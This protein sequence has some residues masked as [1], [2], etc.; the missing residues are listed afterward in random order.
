MKSIRRSTGT[1]ATCADDD[2]DLSV[3]SL[4]LS[5]I[6]EENLICSTAIHNVVANIEKR[7]KSVRFDQVEVI[8]FPYIL[9]DNPSVSFGPPISM[10]HTH[11]DRF[12]VDL[13]EYDDA[14][15]TIHR[16]SMQ[17]MKMDQMLRT[18][19]LQSSGHS[20]RDIMHATAEAQAAQE[21]RRQSVQSSAANLMFHQARTTARRRIQSAQSSFSSLKQS[22]FAT[23]AHPCDQGKHGERQRQRL[24]EP[25]R[26][27]EYSHNR[28]SI[29]I[30]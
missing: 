2:F 27:I 5:S 9:G 24:Q 16:R 23:S 11:Q 3:S 1:L 6:E 21:L 17:E 13:I 29:T 8:E 28:D 14:K 7:K 12:S 26:R 10:T 18:H 19:I 30:L 25:S 20:L 15:Q 22:H 4:S